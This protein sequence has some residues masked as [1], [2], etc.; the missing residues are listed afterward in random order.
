VQ[1]SN[2]LNYE[3]NNNDQ[4]FHTTMKSSKTFQRLLENLKAYQNFLLNESHQQITYVYN[5]LLKESHLKF[6]SG[7]LCEDS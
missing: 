3:K 6:L 7:Y 4:T 5:F 2:H 1:P